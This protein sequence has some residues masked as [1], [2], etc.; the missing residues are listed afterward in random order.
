MTPRGHRVSGGNDENSLELD[1]GS[2][3]RKWF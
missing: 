1:R 2:N 3:A